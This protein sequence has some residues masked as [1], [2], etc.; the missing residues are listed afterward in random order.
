R[1]TTTPYC[2]SLG[3]RDRLRYEDKVAMCGADPFALLPTDF[4]RDCELWPRVEMTDIHD[5]LI[6]MTSFVTRKQLKAHKSL[7]AHNYLTSGWVQEPSLKSVSA[8][9]VI[10]VSQVN[11]SLSLSVPPLKVWLLVKDDGEVVAAHCTCMAGN[12][13]VCSHIA[14]LLFYLEVGVRLRDEQSCTDGLSTWLPPHVRKLEALPI[15]S[16]DFLSST[17]K[18]RRLDATSDTTPQQRHPPKHVPAPTKEEWGTLLD[19]FLAAGHHPCVAAT[20]QRYS[21]LYLPTAKQANGA[22]LRLL[23]DHKATEFTWPELTGYC[24]ELAE[25]LCVNDSVCAAV[26]KRTRGQASSRLWFSYRTGR[27]TAS[28]LKAVCQ[29]SLE[30]PSASLLKKICYPSRQKLNVPAVEYGR[31]SEPKALAKY[32]SLFQA[33]HVNA[34]FRQAGFFICKEHIFLAVTPDLLV[35]WSCCGPAV[36]EVKCPWTVRDGRL[37][38]LYKDPHGPVVEI[39]KAP[40]LKEVQA[41]MFACNVPY[42]DFVLW[43][44]VDITVERVARNEDFISKVKAAQ[45]FFVKVLLPELV[46]HW[47]TRQ[48]E[49]QPPAQRVRTTASANDDRTYCVCSGPDEGPMIACDGENCAIKWFHF[50]CVG[51][52]A[53]PKSKQ[54]FCKTCPKRRTKRPKT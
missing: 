51:L 36:V 52:K 48:K 29:T 17:M 49:N 34:S 47:F 26:E 46:A 43:N 28:V 19:S 45:N 44:E 21:D 9:R 18:K 4:V 13:E 8:N 31:K 1:S 15:S 32:K 2:L 24:D 6:L 39:D 37:K 22:D 50:S 23:Y 7:D 40:F 14:A 5:Y 16:L 30:T 3:G 35:E 33:A 10:V 42:A 27:V 11:H 54:W 53:A 25:R 41:Q 38:D 12:G 20:E